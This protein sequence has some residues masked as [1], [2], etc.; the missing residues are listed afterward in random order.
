[1]TNKSIISAR[2]EKRNGSRWTK[3]GCVLSLGLAS[4]VLIPSVSA[5]GI[6]SSIVT[7]RAQHETTSLP[8]PPLPKLDAMPWL[9]WPWT[10][11][12]LKVD[13]LMLPPVKPGD[14]LLP[15]TRSTHTGSTAASNPSG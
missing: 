9:M 11:K 13:T 1:M 8:L 3:L 10:I 12:D 14:F 5:F 2:A 7:N 4:A 15:Q 6:E